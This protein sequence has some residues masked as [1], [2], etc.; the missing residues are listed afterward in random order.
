MMLKPKITIG[1]ERSLNQ[2]R[3]CMTLM[4]LRLSNP[5]SYR[6]VCSRIACVAVMESQS[7]K[8]PKSKYSRKKSANYSVSESSEAHVVHYPM[9]KSEDL[10]PLQFAEVRRSKKQLKYGRKERLWEIRWFAG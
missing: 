1:A 2:D 4:R 8:C 7:G 9:K 3:Y 5:D 10:K 6:T